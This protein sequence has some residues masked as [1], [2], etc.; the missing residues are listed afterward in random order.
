[1]R[2]LAVEPNFAK[3]GARVFVCGG[4]ASTH[5]LHEKG[6]LGHKEIALHAAGRAMYAVRLLAWA[7]DLG[8]KTYDTKSGTRIT[9]VNPTQ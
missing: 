3:C 1:M 9:F 2:M 7:N 4:A 6:W 8:T 5:G